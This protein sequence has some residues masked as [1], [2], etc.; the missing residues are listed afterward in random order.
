[1]EKI[2]YKGKVKDVYDLNDKLKFKFSNR[3]SV[4]DQIIPN[5]I[6]VKGEV[7]CRISKFWFEKVEE[8]KICKTHYIRTNDCKNDEMIVKKTKVIPLE[9]IVRYYNAGS[10]YKRFGGKYGEKF[11]TPIFEITTKFEKYDRILTEEEALKISKLKK[12]DLEYIKEKI[13]KVDEL[14][15]EEVGKRNLIHVDG[16]KE[17]G[18]LND[19]IL[20]IDTF[21]TPDEDRFWDKEEYEKGNFVELSKEFVRKYYENLFFICPK[22]KEK[23]SY[24]EFL[25]AQREANLQEPLIPPLPEE[26]VKEIENLYKIMYERIT[27]MKF[28]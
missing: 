8:K 7:L 27:G 16:K 11:A 6:K 2:L 4:F 12:E 15:Q 17:F 24:R 25:Y 21:G 10:Y 13:L 19:E 20:L 18:I 14:I 5:E 9:F 26:K 28:F 1:M 22:C 23:F 3:I